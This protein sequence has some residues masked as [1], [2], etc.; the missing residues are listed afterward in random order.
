[1]QAAAAFQDSLSLLDEHVEATGL[2]YA[3]FMDDWGDPRPGPH[4]IKNSLW[5]LTR[6]NLFRAVPFRP[7]LYGVRTGHRSSP[8]TPDLKA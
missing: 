4:P 8:L 1:M 5:R 3:R 7:M 2:A 6:S